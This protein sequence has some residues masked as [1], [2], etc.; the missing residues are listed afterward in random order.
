MH[1]MLGRKSWRVWALI[2]GRVLVGYLDEQALEY[3]DYDTMIP[4]P[5]F[6]GP[7]A[8]RSWGQIDLIVHH[9]SIEDAYGWPF[10][11]DTDVIAKTAETE[12]MSRKSWVRREEI[13][14]QELRSALSVPDRS[15]VVGQRIL[16]IDDVFT[17]GHAMLEVARALRLAG[18]AAVDGLVLARAQW[19]QHV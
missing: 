5:A 2:L 6:T 16:I 4:M 15:A 8:H 14:T 17:T 19:Q 13:A 1:M 12:P 7:G 10:R 3:D 18:A 11:R 9:A